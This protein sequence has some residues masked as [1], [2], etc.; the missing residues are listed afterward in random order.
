M[1]YFTHSKIF[2]TIHTRLDNSTNKGAEYYD[3]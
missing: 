2:V 3:R 1:N